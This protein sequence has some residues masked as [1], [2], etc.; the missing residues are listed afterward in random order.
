MA[1][2]WRAL[3]GTKN[4][5]MK[6]TDPTAADAIYDYPVVWVNTTSNL[7]WL[8]KDGAINSLPP[9]S[10]NTVTGDTSSTSI[11][12][13]EGQISDLQT[14]ID[15]AIKSDPTGGQYQITELALD[16]NKKVV[17]THSDTPEA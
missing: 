9:T 4:T 10:G 11:A 13:L 3:E 6:T 8:L 17:V 5:L 16:A 1:I 14:E 7:A 2:N 12:D 15:G